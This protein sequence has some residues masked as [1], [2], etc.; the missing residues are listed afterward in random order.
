MGHPFPGVPKQMSRRLLI[1]LAAVCLLVQS[2]RSQAA[3]PEIAVACNEEFAKFLVDQQV[4]ESRTVEETDKRIRILI[5]A[6]DFLWKYD[7]PAARAHLTEAFKIAGDRF[8]EKGFEKR[9][10]KGLTTVLPDYR[11]EV[12]KAV[13]AKDAEWAKV[14]IEQLLKEYEKESASREGFDKNRE[15][16]DTLRIAVDSLK[17]NPELSRALFRRA[18]QHPLDFHWFWTMF[19]IAAANRQLADDVYSELLT[20]YANATPRR[21]LFLSAYPFASERMLGIEKFQYGASVPEALTPNRNLQQRFIETFLR[22]AV[23]YAS[24]PANA[25]A[26]PEEHRLP[27]PIYIA[28][29]LNELEPI[30]VQDFPFLIQRLSEARAQAA[31]MLD[32]KMRKDA[33]A[34]ES[35][36]EEMGWGFEKRLKEL[37]K[38]EANGKLTDFMIVNLLTWGDNAK[39]AE[40]FKQIEPWLDKIKEPAA[41]EGTINYFWFLRSKLAIK[42]GRIADAEKFAAKVPELEHRAILF[43]E[44]AEKQLKNVNDAA[45]VYSTLREVG[46]LGEQAEDST[47]KARVLLGLVNQY[48]KVNQVFAMQELADAVKVVNRIE[49]PD[50]LSDNTTRQ[51]KGKNF[52][53]FASFSMPG[54]GLENTFKEISKNNFELS[55]S[56]AKALEDKY[57][58]T[59]AVLAIA[60]NCVDLAPKK[61]VR[62]APASRSGGY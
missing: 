20:T 47:E 3:V 57:F 37:E 45:T 49:K 13:A 17:V 34:R 21:L 35:R 1:L 43:F 48:L 11:F 25:S 39:T 12:I 24:D 44:I 22:R 2:V 14:L 60:K 53:F 36:N 62:K 7:Q 19:S 5:R 8:K 50:L 10:N 54:Y 56:N 33:D 28:T 9:E 16:D 4:G 55:L 23:S 42:E 26:A 58:R 52:A 41:C 40:Q 38:A 51:I 29:T 31:G 15:L 27:E 18:M 59:I 30:V 32:E 46:R 61:P 6:A